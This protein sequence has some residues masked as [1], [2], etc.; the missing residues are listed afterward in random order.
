MFELAERMSRLGTESAFQVLARARAL[1][2]QGRDIIHLEI[3]EP[4]FATPDHIIEAACRA[5][6]EGWTHYTPT[7]GIPELCNVIAQQIGERRGQSVEPSQ[8]VVTPGAKPIMFYVLLAL[9]QPGREVIYPDPGFPIYK[10]MIDFCGAKAVPLPLREELDFRFQ[11][12][13]LR[14]L[15]NDR[16]AL[17]ILNSPHNPT[18]GIMEPSDLASIADLCVR[19]NIPVLSDEV[20]EQILYDGAFHSIAT[21]PGMSTKERTIILHGFSK[22]YAMTGWRLGYGVM[23]EWLAEH[24]KRLMVNSNSCT[25]AATQWA[26]VAAL[27]G[28]QEPVAQMV[29]AF[30]KRRQVIVEGLNSIPGIT[31]RMPRGAFYVFPNITG[32]GLASQACEDLLLQKAGVATLSGT[33]FGVTGEG[34][35]RLSYANSI[36]NIEKAVER[37]RTTLASV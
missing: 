19:H 16:T 25:N 6:H 11:L 31:C 1:E 4:D 29:E 21:Y 35:L 36:E 3:G 8:V 37:I 12:D 22:T 13:D 28:T 10:S 2:A 24:V 7:Q 14:P 20:Y 26:G 18:G 33:S 15:I 27:T 34:Y 17:I 5:L 32:T 23:P 9:A 30:R